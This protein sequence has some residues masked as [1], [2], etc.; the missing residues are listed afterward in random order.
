MNVRE[1]EAADEVA[2]AK[3]SFICQSEREL[4]AGTVQ[5]AKLVLFNSLAVAL[6]LQ[7]A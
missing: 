1:T 4:D 3:A 2:T 6:G 5:A 7:I